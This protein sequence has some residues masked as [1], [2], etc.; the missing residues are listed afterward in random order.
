MNHRLRIALFALAAAAWLVAI[1]KAQ[2]ETPNR[3]FHQKTSFR[4]EGRHQAVACD[5]CHLKGVFKGTPT[6]CMDCHWIRRQDDRF[7]LQLGSQCEQCHTATSWAPA[8]FDHAAATGTPLIGAHRLLA[9]QDCHKKGDLRSA[10]GGCASCHLQDYLSAR[11]PD[12][13]ASG[14]PTTCET[15]HRAGDAS[16]KLARFDHQASFPLQGQHALQTCSTC[17]KNNVYQGT[18]R[19]CVGCHRPEYDRTTSPPHAAAGFPTTCDSC[20]RVTDSSFRGVTFNH[21]SV[22]ALQ[23]RHAQTACAT[24]H[25]NNVYR[26]TARECAGCHRQEYDR[27]TSPPHAAAG[28]PTTCDSCH[29]VTDSSFRGITF[30]HSSVFP[31]QGQHSQ[32]ACTACHQN[33]VYR[34]TPRACAGCH[35]TDYNRTTSPPHAAAGFPTTCDTCHRATDSSFLGAVF[36]HSAVFPLVGRHAQ[37]SCVACHQNNVY[38]GTP[39][40]CVGCHLADY[41]RTSAPSHMAAGFP[42]TCDSCHRDTDSNWTQGRF[43]HRFPIT[44]GNH[45]APCTTCHTNS[46]SYQIF[47]CLTCHHTQSETAKEHQGISGFRYDSLACYGCHPNGKEA[48]LA[49]RWTLD[50]GRWTHLRASRYGG[51]ALDPVPCHVTDTRRRL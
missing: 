29:R 35:L 41:N 28:F 1:P 15:C 20:H 9:C 19:E 8:R 14:F 30:N 32:Q 47:T 11:E 48:L 44:S 3:Q 40:A 34:G 22:F 50:P 33:N 7:K 17:H 12:H 18:P 10:S 26:G 25:V 6:A 38:R 4:L 13:A 23:G 27:T 37:Q 2:F 5:S 16:F 39:R 36:N 45:N 51:Q 31:L 43:V 46:A 49:E 24:C 21:N 42:T